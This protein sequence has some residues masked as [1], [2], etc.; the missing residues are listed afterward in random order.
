MPLP[1]DI[2]PIF[3]DIQD[4]LVRSEAPWVQQTPMSSVKVLWVGRETGTWA[5]L[6]HWKKGYVAPP[7]KHLAGAHAFIVSGKLQVRNGVLSA[8][9]YVYEPSGILHDATTALEDTTYLFT[10]NGAVLFFDEN[11]FTRYT[12]WEVVEKLRASAVPTIR[13]EAAE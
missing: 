2:R 10:C 11:G 12:N 6:H 3:Q 1:Q 8:G 9:D 13:A 7:H 5:S 4:T